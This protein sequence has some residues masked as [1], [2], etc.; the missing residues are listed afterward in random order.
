MYCIYCGTKLPDN[1]RF[2]PSCGS[3]TQQDSVNAN[4]SIPNVTSTTTNGF[5]NN[6]A[7]AK[8]IKN[9]TAQI[10][11]LLLTIF[12]SAILGLMVGLAGL[13]DY[14]FY[15]KKGKAFA[16][17]N[18]V[19]SIIFGIIRFILF[20]LLIIKLSENWEVDPGLEGDMVKIIFGI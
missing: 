12:V 4:T 5:S 7:P 17:F 2:C 18:I 13:S 9:N 15:D 16:V 1:A 10:W 11:G 20:I 3:R 6:P 19:F 8:I 14:K